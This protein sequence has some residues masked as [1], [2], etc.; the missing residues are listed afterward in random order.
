MK[1]L[2]FI[3]ALLTVYFCFVLNSRLEKSEAELAAARS[4]IKAAEEQL[5]PRAVLDSAQNELNETEKKFLAL[6]DELKNS[7]AQV[8]ALNEWVAAMKNQPNLPRPTKP[9]PPAKPG[10]IKGGFRLMDDSMVY[11]PESQYRLGEDLFVTSPKGPMMSDKEQLIFGGDLL[12]QTPQGTIQG[13][14]A[15]LEVNGDNATLTA[16]QVK[17]TLRK[18]AE[19]VTAAQPAPASG[20]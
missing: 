18:S 8:A 3:I 17:V 19:A 20:R 13:D 5:V 4:K 1:P 12:L 10:L 11:L 6:A 15:V 14:D 16:K 7:Q 2:L 9:K